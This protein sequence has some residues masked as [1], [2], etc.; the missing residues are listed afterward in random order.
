M[1]ADITGRTIETIDGAQEVGAKGGAVMA[2]AASALIYLRFVISGINR[3]NCH[4]QSDTALSQ[5]V[6]FPYA[7]AGNGTL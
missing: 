2:T 3:G 6:P 4:K 1:L 5:A 7:I